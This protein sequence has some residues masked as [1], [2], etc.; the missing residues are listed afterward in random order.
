MKCKYG[1]SF[2]DVQCKKTFCLDC[3][4]KQEGYTR[5]D[6]VDTRETESLDSYGFTL[7]ANAVNPFDF[8]K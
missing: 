1:Y 5:Q 3:I 2:N 8:H 6:V 4:T 7:Y